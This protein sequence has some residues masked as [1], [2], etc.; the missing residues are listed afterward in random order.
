L[1]TLYLDS[2]FLPVALGNLTRT[3]AR[4]LEMNHP[5]YFS[6]IVNAGSLLMIAP[7]LVIYGL[8]QRYFVESIE[9]TGLVG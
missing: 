3:L 6:L 8:L 1:T 4:E 5:Q 2:N 9:R 7:V